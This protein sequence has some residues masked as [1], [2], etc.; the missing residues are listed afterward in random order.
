VVVK[1]GFEESCIETEA[2]RRFADVD[3]LLEPRQAKVFVGFF[4]S[5]DGKRDLSLVAGE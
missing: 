2:R 5:R 1:V 4:G 3:R